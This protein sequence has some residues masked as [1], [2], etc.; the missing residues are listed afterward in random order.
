MKETTYENLKEKLEY[1]DS[2][3]ELK[4]IEKAYLFANEKH[5][6]RVRKN[7]ESYISHPLNVALILCDLNVDYV[8]IASALMHECINHAETTYEE[9]VESFGEEIADIVKAIS[10]IN[11]LTLND[12]KES[13]AVQLRKVLVGLSSDVRVL[14]IKLA[15][16]LHNMRT[17]WALEEN[18]IKDKIYETEAVLIPI[19]ARLGINSIKSELEDLCLRYSKPDVYQEI[20]DRLEKD[21]DNLNDKL[22]EI[23]A[24]ISNI[25]M[26]HGIKF[27]IKARVKSVHSIYEKMVNGH[28]WDEIYD[29]LALRVIV[30]EVAE[31]YLTIGLIHAKYRPL[32]NRFKD[33]IANPKGNMYQ[34]LH[35]SVIGNDGHVFELQ[36]RTYKMDEIAEKGIASHWSYKE[37]SDGSKTNYMEEKLELFRNLIEQNSEDTIEKAVNREFLGKMIYCF[38]PKGDVVELPLHSTPVDFAYRIHSHVGDTTVGALVNDKIVSLDSE[39]QDG[40]RV[41]IKTDRNATPSREWLSFVNTTQAKTKIKSYFSKQ[42]KERYIEI[43]KEL[44][45]KELRKRKLSINE[46]LNNDNVNKLLTDL[47]LNDTDE[48]YLSIGSLRYT[49]TFIINSIYE[50]KKDV[51]EKKKKK[52]IK[53]TTD[54]IDHKSDVIVSGMDNI[55]VRFANCCKPIKGDKI[56]GYIT[57]GSGITIHREDCPNINLDKKRLIDVDWNGFAE[58]DYYCDIKVNV[59]LGKNYLAD[60]ISLILS[61]GV[62][63]DGVATQ[64][65]NNFLIYKLTLK[66]KSTKDLNIII[67]KLDNLSYVRKV[68]RVRD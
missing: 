1:I 57:M 64:N 62:S 59:E 17:I 18:E 5:K 48:I 46:T 12:D 6:G 21:E 14:Y 11:R 53:Q 13:T 19:A 15:D 45:E 58:S 54:T 66:V 51:E 33:Y 26:E 39:L 9:I 24:D 44:L 16:R 23:K 8:T 43:G 40:D 30:E 36:V 49:P 4:I 22:E 20:L 61:K 65:E 32:P 52:T 34:S 42:D 37:H 28:K 56:K 41:V 35:T 55:K 25:L 31:C 7:G 50:E 38:T 47:K 27:K 10:K 60:I 2:V 67:S 29:I 63:V 68:E 3:E